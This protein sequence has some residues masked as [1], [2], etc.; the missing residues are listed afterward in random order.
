MGDECSNKPYVKTPEGWECKTSEGPGPFVTRAIFIDPVGHSIIW[1]SRH[2]RKHH[3]HLDKS[4]GSTW[5]APGAIGWWIAILFAIGSV[6]FALGSLPSYFNVVS[7]TIDG[8]TFFIGSIFFT[9]AAFLQYL[10]TVNAPVNLGVNIKERL[11]VL[12]WE[13]GRIDWWS[14]AVQFGGTIFF[15]ITTFA[16]LQSFLLVSQ[17]NHM[18]WRPDFYGSICFLIA[19]YLAWLRWGMVSGP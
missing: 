1:T 15:N 9:T 2:H 3:F 13:P 18:V 11:H 10:E 6:C 14:T 5:W 4:I 7:A 16:A 12:T 19:T 8:E 17:I